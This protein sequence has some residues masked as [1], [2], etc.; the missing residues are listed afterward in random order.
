MTLR[1]IDA[2]VDEIADVDV[3]AM[4][5]ARA[6]QATLT[7]PAGSLGRLEELAVQ[8]AGM[9]GAAVPSVARKAVI[10]MAGDHGIAAQGVSAYP[11]EVTAQMVAN[12]A[13][14][15]AAVNVIAR[16]LGARVVVVDIGVRVPIVA[17]ALVRSRRIAAGTAD[18]SLAPAMSREDAER[19]IDAGVGIVD[20]DAARGLDLS[21]PATWASATRPPPARSPR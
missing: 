1:R 19:A 20:E 7:K 18:F 9:R 13:R 5:A 15:G 14:G 4:D 3:T 16:T 2:L 11:A 12:Y 10:V 17:D 6:R 8:I 21:R